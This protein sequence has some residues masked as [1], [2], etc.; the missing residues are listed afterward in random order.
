VVV[1]WARRKARGIG[2][3]WAEGFG[4]G[5]LT[6]WTMLSQTLLVGLPA[7]LVWVGCV[8][9]SR[10]TAV[11]GGLPIG[12]GASWLALA[13]A[14]WK[15]GPWVWLVLSAALLIAGIAATRIALRGQDEPDARMPAFRHARAIVVATV[16]ASLLVV[17]F[18]LPVRPNEYAL[19]TGLPA[20]LPTACGGVGLDAVVRGSPND[21]RI[22]WLENHLAMPQ[23]V[24][25][26]PRLEATWPAGYRARFTPKLEIL[27]NWGNVVLREGDAV[28]GTCSAGDSPSYYLAPPFT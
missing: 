9:R 6:G 20:W 5:A 10:R 8:L 13:I 12:L 26:T 17:G 24:P 15:S 28:T 23:G 3:A 18:G 1:D 7:G 27:D 2:P 16:V 19:P 22:A 4:V 14:D 21:P 25:T 11:R